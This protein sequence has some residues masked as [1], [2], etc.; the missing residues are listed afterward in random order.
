[1]RDRLLGR[2][3]RDVDL[4]VAGD[5]G[6]ACREVA[7]K[8]GATV[9]VMD[10]SRG[11]LRIA[12]R[13]RA[14]EVAGDRSAPPLA[15]VDIAP[16]AGSLV[17]DLLRRDFTL[18]ALAVPLDRWLDPRGLESLVDPAGGRAD[19][20]ARVIRQ[21]SSSALG[22]DPV[23]TVRACR[24]AAALGFE[25][26]PETSAAVAAHAPLA[27]H[28]AAERLRVE[29][30]E[31]IAGRHAVHGIRL[32]DS[33]GLLDALLPEVCRGR[34]VSQPRQH[35][36]WDVFEHSV[37]TVGEAERLL[38]RELRST[39][40]IV[41]RLAWP[42]DLEGHFDEVVADDLTRGALLKVAAL[43]HDVAKPETKAVQAD[44]RTRFLGHE[45][46]G[47]E[48]AA[49]ILRR[50]RASRRT[51]AHVSLM[52]QEHLR[53]VQL[54]DVVRPPTARAIFR[55]FRDVAPVAVDTVFLAAADYLAARGPMLDP[56]DWQ[57][58]ADM[59]GDILRRGFE[60][61]RE[62]KPS[63][64]F[65]GYQVQRL[66]GLPPG[67]EIGRL[68]GMLREAEAAGEVQTQ[69]EA[70]DLLR[71]AVREGGGPGRSS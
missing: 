8:A 49:G 23:R 12:F 68:L 2:P 37:H 24:F 67:P 38:D 4:I 10:A 62:S 40:A 55:Y 58:H 20:A 66:L 6:P 71:E 28:G 9:V 41:T 69:E 52:V 11:H 14:G 7:A 19:L 59:L 33:H 15:W 42:K 13:S 18:N 47:A 5:P 26:E 70:L 31:T 57:R 34:G 36:H 29:L 32:L 64:L 3:Y 63:L 46:R 16:R 43:L 50:Y 51:I 65:D 1:V 56:A 27:A 61:Q 48:V 35:H 21:V 39:D 44:G 45:E 30:F 22:D 17:D 60:A 53:P 25:I 54:S